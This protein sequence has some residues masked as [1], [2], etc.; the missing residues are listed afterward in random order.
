MKLKLTESQ[1]DRLKANLSESGDDNRYSREVKVAFN[2]YVDVK[3]K[4]M[5]INGYSE[6]KAILF[7]T[8]TIIYTK[9]GIDGIM[10]DNITGPKEIETDIEY[11]IDG[12]NT[13][14]DMITL[15]IDWSKLTTD[16]INNGA[17][18]S[19]DDI[20]RVNLKNDEQGN[21][22]VNNLELIVYSV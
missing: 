2:N 8:I 21:L 18:I 11:Y 12:D 22:F 19:I 13:T 9:S 10:L 3:Y 17:Q 14:T 6:P 16:K 15:P 4:G 20:L 1:F 7:Y 5:E